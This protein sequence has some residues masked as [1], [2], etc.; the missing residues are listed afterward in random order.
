MI[1]VITVIRNAQKF[2]IADEYR[3]VNLLTGAK[4]YRDLTGLQSGGPF[5]APAPVLPNP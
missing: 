2:Q 1:F 3:E 4:V 5:G